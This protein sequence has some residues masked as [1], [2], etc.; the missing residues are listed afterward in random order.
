MAPSD[1]SRNQDLHQREAE[2]RER[3]LSLQLKEMEMEL[4]KAK[5]DRLS[6]ETAAPPAQQPGRIRR[7]RRNALEGLKLFAVV[8]AVMAAIRIA[9]WLASVLMVLGVGYLVYKLYFAERFNR[10]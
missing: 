10:D 9:Y 6:T 3:E 8:V 1:D 7:W 4:Q 5:G 2:L